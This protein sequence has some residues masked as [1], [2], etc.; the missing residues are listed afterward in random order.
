MANR[1][2]G[3]PKIGQPISVT[4]TPEQKAWIDSRIR[5]RGTRTEVIRM[6]IQHA[7]TS[8]RWRGRIAALLGRE[9]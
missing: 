5:P 4:L 7:M 6:I 3:R 8:S 1:T 2:K 9:E